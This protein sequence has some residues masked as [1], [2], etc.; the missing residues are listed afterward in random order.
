MSCVYS[1]KEFSHRSGKKVVMEE[2]EPQ[3]AT[4]NGR[5]DGKIQWMHSIGYYEAFGSNVFDM[6]AARWRDLKD[7]GTE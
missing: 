1:A 6:H 5:A 4:I 3:Q 7:D 2:V